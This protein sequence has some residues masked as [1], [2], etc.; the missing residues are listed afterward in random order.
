MSS[1]W[2][3]QDRDNELARIDAVSRGV[4]VGAVA[5]TLLFGAAVAWGDQKREAAQEAEDATGTTT[6]QPEPAPTLTA[7]G[8]APTKTKPSATPARTATPTPTKSSK[9]KSGGS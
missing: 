4:A 9:P 8:K 5:A 1:P 2:T 7:P 3:P 6:D